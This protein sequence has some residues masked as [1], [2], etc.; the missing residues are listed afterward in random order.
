MSN[1]PLSWE[2]VLGSPFGL[3]LIQ[4]APH[5]VAAAVL[6]QSIGLDHNR[7]LFYQMFE[8][9]AETIQADHPEADAPAWKRFRANMY[10][11]EFDFNVGAR[12][13]RTCMTPMLV[14]MRDDAYHPAQ[15][16]R[17]IAELAPNAT[18][19]EHWNSPETDGTIETVVEFLKRKTPT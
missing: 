17:Q 4:A 11:G 7:E 16:S 14:L 2:P 6:Q 12:F 1:K 10:D 15:T 3:G 8:T 13:V 5:C 18:L 9:W 19:V